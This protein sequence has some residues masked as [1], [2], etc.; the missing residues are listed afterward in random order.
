MPPWTSTSCGYELREGPCYAAVTDERFIVVNDL[1]APDNP[2]VRFGPRAVDL[3]VR[4]QTAIQL[5]H[6]GERGLSR[7]DRT[8]APP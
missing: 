8:S 3:G 1:A 2:Y 7:A 6:N 4:A 5:A